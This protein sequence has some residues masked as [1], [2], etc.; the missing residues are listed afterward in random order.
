MLVIGEAQDW[1]LIAYAQD[2]V[3][4]GRKKGLIV[5][6]HVLSEQ[7]GMNY[8]AE[9]LKGFVHEVPVRFVPLV[10]PYWNPAR[11]VFEI[12]TRI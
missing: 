2:L 7:W 5:L 1:D 9:W 10:E 3:T 4:A 11:P 12:N 6:G 8:C